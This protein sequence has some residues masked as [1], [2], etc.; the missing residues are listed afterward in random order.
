M[1]LVFATRN[2][3]K[4]KEIRSLVPQ[5][6]ELIGLDDI[7]CYEDISE[8]ANTIEANAM[9]K[10]T[11]VYEKYGYNVFADDTGLEVLSLN[12]EPGVRS[13]RY[14]GESKNDIANINKLLYNLKFHSNRNACFKTVIALILE[15]KKYSF[16]GNVHGSITST[17]KGNNG[18][19]YDS[20]FCPENSNKTFA[21]MELDEKNKISHRTKAIKKMLDFVQTL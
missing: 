3:N 8:E 20:V 6:I 13:A 4:I 9:L 21:E 19:G 12:G 14:A 16:E 11:Y 2:I 7:G 18:F 17:P 5:K 15:G 10:A 1:R